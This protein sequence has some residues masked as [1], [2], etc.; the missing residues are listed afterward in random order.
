[1][2][3]ARR[4][5]ERVYINYVDALQYIHSLFRFGMRPGL[6]RTAE[7]LRRLGHPEQAGYRIVHVTGTNGKGSTCAL[8]AAG[9]QAAGYR[10]GLYIS[11]FLE[12]WTERIQLDGRP[13]PPEDVAA[14]VTEVRPHVEAMVGEGF[15]QPTEFEVTTAVALLYYARM[16]ADWVVLEVGLG[17]RHDATNVIERPAV[18]CITNV[19]LDH[20]SVLGNTPEE[21]AWDKAGI[22]KPGVPCVMAVE[23]PGAQGVI[24]HVAQEVGAPVAPVRAPSA[25]SAW[26][27]DG[28]TFD[29]AGRWRNGAG[30][31]SPGNYRDLRLRLAG[32]HQLANAACAVA[33][34][35][36]CGVREEAVRSGLAAAAWP[37]RFEWVPL[38]GPESPGVILDGAHN[39]AGA[40]ALAATVRDYLVGRRVALVLGMLADKKVQPV[41]RHLLPLADAVVVTTPDN[42]PRALPA[43]ELARRIHRALAAGAGA[44]DL[45][46]RL[47]PTPCLAVERALEWC[48]AGDVVLVT[49]SLYTVGPVRT[50]LRHRSRTGVL[51]P[52]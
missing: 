42:A 14:L 11:P 12:E 10:T 29:L 30:L 18:T 9:L 4:P 25:P 35:E 45:P 7:L 47:A 44:L 16:Q 15:E 8:V 5:K 27:L 51:A 2:R 13:I 1:M 22:L 43:P 40:R 37:G 33:V 24:R 28:Q 48:V 3:R 26:G 17:G 32:R 36:L 52:G 20:T 41:L 19:A 38:N 49:G 23:H 46:I 21:I 34:L 31:P 39:P 6:D 50:H